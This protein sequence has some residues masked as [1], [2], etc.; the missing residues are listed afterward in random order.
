VIHSLTA[1]E[2]HTDNGAGSKLTSS[3]ITS[4]FREPAGGFVPKAITITKS[5]NNEISVKFGENLP[6]LEKLKSG[7]EIPPEYLH[8]ILNFHVS[9]QDAQGNVPAKHLKRIK[10]YW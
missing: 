1:A 5:G 4:P 2:A 10:A 7:E 3:T 8:G 6:A 9:R